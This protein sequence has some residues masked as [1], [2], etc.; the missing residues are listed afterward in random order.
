MNLDKRLFKDRDNKMLCGVLAG[1]AQYING[2][3]TL[4]RILFVLMTLIFHPCIIIYIAAAVIMPYK[5]E[6]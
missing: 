2:D 6:I 1:F 3:V 5:D 4:V